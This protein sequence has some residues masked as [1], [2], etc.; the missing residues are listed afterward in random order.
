MIG[1]P[2]LSGRDRYERVMDGRVDNTHDDAFTHT[3][4]LSD[5][6]RSVEVR[7]VCTASPGYEVQE[8][9]ARVLSGAVDPGIVAEFPRLAGARMV[10]GFTKCLAEICGPREGAGLFVDAGIEVARLARQVTRMPASAV[11]S[12]A[13]GD[14]E[15]CWAL[16]MAGWVDLPDSCFTYSPA[17]RALFGTRPVSSPMVPALYSPPPGARGVFTRKKVARLV[18]TGTR[19][20]LFHSMHDNVHGFDVHYEIDLDRET[21]VVADS[22]TSRLPYAGICTEPQAR[23]ESLRG[24]AVDA[25]LRKRIQS[26]IG[27]IGGCAQLYD[28]TSDLLKLLSIPSTS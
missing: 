4:R 17:G 11:A 8:A 25:A 21:I 7:A 2:F 19:L 18:L 10:G 13:P 1:S 22:I 27:G 24:Q 3:V 14:A 20:H 5:P 16:D 12:L 6:D 15:A 26:Q 28:L 9:G 23:I